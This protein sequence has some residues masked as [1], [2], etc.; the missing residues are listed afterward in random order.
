[1]LI[2]PAKFFA[3]AWNLSV[4]VRTKSTELSAER[5]ERNKLVLNLLHC[6]LCAFCNLRLASFKQAGFPSPTITP[7]VG[8]YSWHA[9][10]L[11]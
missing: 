1:M 3:T 11:T 2:R 4:E 10:V 8:R 9:E 6:F 7:I 5:G